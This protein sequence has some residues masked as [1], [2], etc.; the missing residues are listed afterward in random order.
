VAGTDIGLS[1]SIREEE[2]DGY[3]KEGGKATSEIETK[4]KPF[5]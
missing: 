5:L 1:T 2:G 3:E 4:E